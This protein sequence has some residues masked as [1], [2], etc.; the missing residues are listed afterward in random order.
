MVLALAVPA[1]ANLL[2]DGGFEQTTANPDMWSAPIDYDRPESGPGGP[3]EGA[4][5]AGVQAGCTGAVIESTMTSVV[6]APSST[7]VL[8]GMWHVA[9][10][11]PLTGWVKLVDGS[12]TNDTTIASCTASGIPGWAPFELSG[13]IATGHVKIKFGFQCGAGWNSGSQTS[14]DGLVLEV[15]PEPASLGLFALAGLPFLRRRR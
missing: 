15:V 1:S 3:A 5:Y 10:P 12:S 4:H 8:T 11:L 2:Q 6:V 9:G 14:V 7:V 13:H